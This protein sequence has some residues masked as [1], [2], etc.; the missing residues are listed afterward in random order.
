MCEVYAPS[1]ARRAR[2]KLA[3]TD[4]AQLAGLFAKLA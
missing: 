2:A 4:A 3:D 1:I